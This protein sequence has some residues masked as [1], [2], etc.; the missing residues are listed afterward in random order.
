M[1]TT[2]AQFQKHI[3]SP[4]SQGGSNFA[5]PLR[6]FLQAYCLRRTEQRLELPKSTQ[7][8]MSLKL[9]TEERDLYDQVV[10]QTK[11]KA[12]SLVSQGKTIQ[13]YN[14]LFTAILQMRILCNIGTLNPS[15]ESSSDFLG[16]QSGN[17]WCERCF[18]RDGDTSI[19]LASFQFCPDCCRPLH[20]ASPNPELSPSP[21]PNGPVMNGSRTPESRSQLLSLRFLTHQPNGLSTKLS[22]IVQNVSSDMLDAKQ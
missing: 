19:L 16:N 21:G 15:T 18:A 8:V 3:L 14:V 7:E 13:R 1:F 5:K 6:A 20:L 4:L 9:A 10:D 12:D 17:T 11:K 2:K 22:A